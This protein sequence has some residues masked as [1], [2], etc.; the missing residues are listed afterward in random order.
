MCERRIN[1]MLIAL[2][3]GL[4]AGPAHADLV[5]H[6]SLD[7][8]TGSVA[9]DRSGNGNHG[10]VNGATWVDG[11]HGMA[12]SFNGVD[13]YVEMPVVDGLEAMSNMTAAAWINYTDAGDGWLGIM[14]NGQ[15]GGPWET[16]G[17]FVNRGG[18]FLYATV[19]LDGAHVT[20]QTAS[21]AI[22]PDT[23]HHVC[24]T[25]DGSNVRIYV[26]GNLELEQARTG[27]LT[28]TGRAL[29]IGHRIGSSHY[30]TGIID[31]VAVFDH[32]LTE[33]EIRG[34]ME[35]IR[36]PELAADPQPD[37][38][39]LNIPR[40]VTLSWSPGDVAVTHD[41]YFGT[42]LADVNDAAA[43]NPLGV[44]ASQGQDASTFDPG[45]LE[46]SQTYFWRVDEV[47]GA[48]DFTV[49]GGD[50]WS[51]TVEPIAY[52]IPTITATA[53]STF[54]ASGPENTIN[55]SGLVDGL[56]GVSASDMWISGGIPATVD[57]A[58]DRAYKLHE[59]WV[60]N[61]NQLIEAFVGFG[62]KDVVI[63]HSL[64]GENWTVL[65]GVG[66][67]AQAPGTGVMHTTTPSIS[68]VSRPSMFG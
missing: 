64:D 47:N 7:E 21:G 33:A 42:T 53:S 22:G 1:L 68:A 52:P 24:S 4:T 25:W 32:A 45:R 49:F 65:D 3:L 26:D 9:N 14:A 56:H 46:F 37:D 38:A 16:Y 34:I 27:A 35:G 2:V 44:L 17:L 50:I 43:A 66:P 19:F 58:F 40:D 18:T 67:L 60:W 61:S 62:A 31:D 41:V 48:P 54:G 57:Y 59:L 20:Q 6:W 5:G 23:W 10:T 13:D 51:F 28:P 15:Q 8:G 63:E 29:R 55:G 11:R 30:F 39:A 12:L 36:S